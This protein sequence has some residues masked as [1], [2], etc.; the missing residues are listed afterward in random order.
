MNYESE[1]TNW[2]SI[3][4]G[5]QIIGVLAVIGTISFN[6]ISSQMELRKKKAELADST[7]LCES[8]ARSATHGKVQV[9]NDVWGTQ[10]KVSVA[11]GKEGVV[12]R[13]RS[14]GP[15]KQFSTGD[16]I[17]VEKVNLNL[18]RL[19]GAAAGKRA[20]RFIEGFKEGVKEGKDEEKKWV[21]NENTTRKSYPD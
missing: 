8:L 3:F 14:A 18:S 10:I 21:E 11:E 6:F 19:A 7:R 9:D 4:Y 12:A 17:V 13:A 16:D 1:K 15:D 20:I 5:I 2:K